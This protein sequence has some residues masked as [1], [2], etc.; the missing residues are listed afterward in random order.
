MKLYCR[1][2]LFSF[3]LISFIY[4]YYYYYY[5]Y[6]SLFVNNSSSFRLVCT[7]QLL[8]C[9][10]WT[11][12]SFFMFKSCRKQLGSLESGMTLMS[13][14]LLWKSAISCVA[15][16]C[17]FVTFLRLMLLCT[18][19]YTVHVRNFFIETAQQIKLVSF[20]LCMEVSPIS[21]WPLPSL[22]VR[23]WS[24]AGSPPPIPIL[25]QGWKYWGDYSYA[26]FKYALYHFWEFAPKAKQVHPHLYQ[27]HVMGG[28]IG[29]I[30][31]C[32]PIQ[33]WNDYV[34]WVDNRY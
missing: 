24:K 17:A 5:Y 15:F 20:R 6:P 34:F 27:F 1:V 8:C 33:F 7:C 29:E 26:H 10:Q 4:Y 12:F 30:I 21:S 31:Q 23:P 18:A 2:T 11:F 19:K 16:H 22:R 3:L 13:N 28:I 32:R 25:C 9:H 14:I